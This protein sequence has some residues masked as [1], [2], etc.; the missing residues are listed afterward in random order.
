[1]DNFDDDD[2][3]VPEPQEEDRG[4]KVQKLYEPG[5]QYVKAY[6]FQV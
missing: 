4:E 3:N 1:M 2:G 5:E 6:S